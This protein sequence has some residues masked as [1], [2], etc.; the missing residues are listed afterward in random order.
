MVSLRIPSANGELTTYQPIHLW[1]T[2]PLQVT[3]FF[4]SQAGILLPSVSI[5]FLFFGAEQKKPN[6]R[7]IAVFN[8]SAGT[9]LI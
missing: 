9:Q 1:R 2:P 4:F 5:L 6:G 8:F 7:L 3:D